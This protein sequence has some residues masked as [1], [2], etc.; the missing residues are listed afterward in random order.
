MER[1]VGLPFLCFR[2]SA[3]P[4]HPTLLA[5][6][7][8]AEALNRPGAPESRAGLF[9]RVSSDF[10]LG[11]LF[12][13]NL[14]LNLFSLFDRCFDMDST[15]IRANSNNLNIF[16]DRVLSHASGPRSADVVNCIGI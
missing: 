7:V 3:P 9:Q 10:E 15:A 12:F 11:P 6:H 2:T 16:H 4:A 1:R 14:N 5:G 8:T 13:I